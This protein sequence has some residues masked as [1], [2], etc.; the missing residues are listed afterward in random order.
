MGPTNNVPAEALVT[1]PFKP[2]IF[3]KRVRKLNISEAK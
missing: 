3:R 2:Y 1:F